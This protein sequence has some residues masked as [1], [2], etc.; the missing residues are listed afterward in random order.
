MGSNTITD[1][2]CELLFLEF[3]SLGAERTVNGFIH[4]FARQPFY[5]AMSLWKSQWL[6]H[7]PVGAL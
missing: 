6:A 5:T 3:W 1:K 4:R 2:L 7:I